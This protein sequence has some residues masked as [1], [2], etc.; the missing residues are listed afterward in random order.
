MLDDRRCVI[1]GLS[2]RALAQSAVKAGIGVFSIDCFADLDTDAISIQSRTIAWD[3][4]GLDS[5]SLVEAIERCDPDNGC[6]P[7]IYGGGLEHTPD[8]LDRISQN[9]RLL[10]NPADTVMRICNPQTFFAALTRLGIPHPATEF[11]PPIDRKFWLLKM[12]G[13]S[14]GT[15]IENYVD[16]V[17]AAGHYFQQRVPGKTITA[18][19]LAS[20]CESKIVGFSEQWFS[21]ADKDRPFTYGGAVSIDSRQA[22][23]KQTL[24][25]IQQHIGTVIT[26]FRLR[27]LLSFDMV[28]DGHRWQL[29]EVNPRPGFTFELHEG[30]DSFIAAHWNAFDAKHTQLRSISLDGIFRAHCIVYALDHIRIPAH[31]KWPNWVTDRNRHDVSVSKY[32]PL[33]TVNAQCSSAEAAR[34][35]VMERYRE[36]IEIASDWVEKH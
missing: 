24:N 8:I 14:G 9:R 4:I 5:R 32:E 31:W 16:Q 7:I 22:I 15:H 6:L 23:S 30:N 13:G 2:V 29:L 28:I 25:S 12:T 11:S 20:E 3:G 21:D 34:R 10:G 36:M 33:C 17:P 35:K 18:T 19:V 26:Y 27:G 1:I